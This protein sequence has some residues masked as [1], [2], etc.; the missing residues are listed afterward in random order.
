[1][2]LRGSGDALLILFAYLETVPLYNSRLPMP[3][4]NSLSL[5]PCGAGGF[6]GASSRRKAGYRRTSHLP[7]RAQRGAGEAFQG[8]RKPRPLLA[9]MVHYLLGVISLG[10]EVGK[11]SKSHV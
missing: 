11:K 5:L 8:K 1:M 4:S 3:L 6:A 2:R 9:V 10:N 7:A